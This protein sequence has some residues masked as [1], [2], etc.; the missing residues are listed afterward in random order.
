MV[1]PAPRGH[2]T[3]TCNK[4]S[5]KDDS[6]YHS[7]SVQTDTATAE[8]SPTFHPK[9]SKDWNLVVVFYFI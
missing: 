9:V 1:S 7:T 6:H 2:N 4:H 8:T 3:E 5:S